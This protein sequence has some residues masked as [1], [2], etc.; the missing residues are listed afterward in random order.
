MQE[1]NRF[2]YTVRT[3]DCDDTQ[4][5]ENILNEMSIEGWDL[6]SLN[7][8]ENDEGEY[9][10]LCIFSREAENIHEFEDEYIVDSGDFK[11][12][13]KKLLHK[14]EDL[15]EECRFLQ[16]HI[17]EKNQKIKD[18]KNSLDLNPEAEDR[19]LLNKEIS[20][21]I[22]ELN[23]LK[24]KFSELL[25]PSG[26]YK[27][28]SQDILTIVVSYELSELIDNEKDGDLIAE[29]V[30]L[31][32]K[33]TDKLGYIIPGI[34]FVI[35]DEMNENEYNIKVR[36]L[37]TLSGV[38]YPK[39]RRFFIGQ[40]NLQT[41]PE[42]AIED[43]DELNE[44]RVFWV[45]EEKTKDF[46][47]GGMTPSQVITS[48]LE[49]IVRKYVEDIISYEDILNYISLLEQEKSFLADNL[50]NEGI[51]LG[52]LRYIFANL[53]REK[54]SV[55][56][57]VF[58]FERLNDLSEYGHDNEKLLKEL[59]LLLKKHICSDIADIN[60]TIYAVIA[61]KQYKKVLCDL[62]KASIEKKCI[63]ESVELEKFV[64]YITNTLQNQEYDASSTAVI[65]ESEYRKPLFNFLDRI[66][67][68]I[69]V[70]SEEE[71]AEEFTVHEI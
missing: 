7:E 52:D 46:W 36:N 60:N 14:K 50:T 63:E 59:R 32:Q 28:I 65:C 8:V 2:E 3:C 26:M 1:E 18:I 33:L 19:E 24:S 51:S 47:E 30:R 68:G 31:R 43:I 10:Y 11:S 9:Q 71:I 38:V 6:Y 61:P 13:M 16:R 21:K 35:S 17:K 69:N 40:S 4:A 54:V 39:H 48:H 29:S 23:L 22:N 37:K 55:K 25:S 66:I 67:P 62:L 45:E 34:H 70:L 53:I 44:Q 57:I 41:P 56:D 64:K 20:E 58:I 49:I 27:R 5:L 15:Y 12:R 42:G